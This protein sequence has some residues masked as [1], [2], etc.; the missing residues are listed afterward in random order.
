MSFLPQSLSHPFSQLPWKWEDIWDASL[1]ASFVFSRCNY[2]PSGRK[3]EQR[4]QS[5]ICCN[6]S[7]Q[8][9][10]TYL[11]PSQPL[12]PPSRF[13]P[14]E[15]SVDFPCNSKTT[16]HQATALWSLVAAEVILTFVRNE[17]LNVPKNFSHLLF[18]CFKCGSTAA[19]NQ[20][21]MPTGVI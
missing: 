14:A 20:V 17:I 9:R 15:L 4:Y 12:E 8:S 21:P 13:D 5:E 18:T 16:R 19:N 10:P 7:L 2:T 3:K 11:M 1:W 6:V